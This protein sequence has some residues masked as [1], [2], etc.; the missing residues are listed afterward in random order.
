M[1]KALTP[2]SV[3]RLAYVR[4][5]YQ[6]GIEH[7]RR[8]SPL[9]ASALLAFHDAVENFVGLAAEHLGAEVKPSTTFLGY[10]EAIKPVLELPGKTS[11]KRLNDAR[12]SLKH[13]GTFPS[14]QA[15]EQAR[16]AVADFFTTVTPAVFHV[17]FD[18][19]DMVDLV[20]QPE[21]AR[22]LREAQTHAD[23]GDITHAMAG[24]HLAFEALLD[25]YAG[26]A[27]WRRS[28]SPFAFGPSL[29]WFD[30][31]RHP[32]KDSQSLVKVMEIVTQSQTALR[33]ISLG[34][35]YPQY[36]RFTALTPQV[37]GY[38]DHSKRY[39]VPPSL[40]ALTAEDYA[41]ARLFVIE[42]ALR[43]ARAE[44]I[45]DLLEEKFKLDWNPREPYPERSWTGAAAAD[46]GDDES[47]AEG[48]LDR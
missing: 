14:E 3:Q 6:E 7:S 35:D 41:W 1:T 40:A 46:N 43:A 4:Y 2:L 45:R 22:L 19:V 21:T 25:H 33:L 8:P 44:G 31:P 26:T 9:S 17:D 27:Y 37:H 10:W 24:L 38:A 29:S 28:E 30:Q 48:T 15:I 12:V 16:E 42:A 5:L 20:P 11:M 34:I 23:V 13:H 18:Q 36:A 39:V 47:A 32:S